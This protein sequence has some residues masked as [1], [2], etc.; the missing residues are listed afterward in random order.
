MLFSVSVFLYISC[1]S[2]TSSWWELQGCYGGWAFFFYYC[3]L[4]C[5]CLCFLI[6]SH[7]THS[8]TIPFIISL[9]CRD[10]DKPPSYTK[11]HVGRMNNG[12]AAWTPAELQL[13]LMEIYKKPAHLLYISC[14]VLMW[15]FIHPFCAAVTALGAADRL[16]H[17]NKVRFVQP[18]AFVVVY[19]WWG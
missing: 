4:R 15:P 1:S 3:I 7:T 18:V 14:A 9:S 2:T 6:S 19:V 13:C 10:Q 12:Y 16:T 8:Y 17:S 11:V 5:Y